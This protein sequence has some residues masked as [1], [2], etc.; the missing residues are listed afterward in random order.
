LRENEE[1][2]K[3]LGEEIQI[4]LTQRK[5]QKITTQQWC[6]LI[7]HWFQL[8]IVHGFVFWFLPIQTNYL[9]YG[10]PYCQ[11]IYGCKDFSENAPLQWF[12]LL[13]LVYFFFSAL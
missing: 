13:Y 3:V 7:L 9:I 8:L 1:L 6:K 12:Y 4:Q 2:L 5:S 11:E 10:S